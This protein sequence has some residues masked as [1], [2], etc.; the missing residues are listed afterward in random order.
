[1]K[2][3]ILIVLLSLTFTPKANALPIQWID[4]GNYYELIQTQLYE[5]T[6]FQARDNAASLSYLG[7][8][9]HL[10]TITSSEENTF[11]ITSFNTRIESEFAWIGGYEPNDDGVWIWAVGP[12]A[13][14]QFSQEVNATAPFN[15]ANWGGIEPNDFNSQE[16]YVMFNLGN[17]F[18]G[19][20]PGQWADADVTPS[21]NDPIHYYLVEYEIL[22]STNVIPEPATML[23]FG[24]GLAGAFLR[25]RKMKHIELENL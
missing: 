1:M 22:N 7:V 4:N 13:G 12:E 9:G 25:K 11:L 5:L 14:I 2:R 15:Y 6:W 23:L 24:T 10:A 18:A 3:L 16:D 8:S 20:L 19:I 17:N 21:G